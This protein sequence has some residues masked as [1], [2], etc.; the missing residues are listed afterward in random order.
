M[1]AAAPELIDLSGETQ[2]TLD[3][4]GVDRAGAEGCRRPRR[5]ARRVSA[6][7]PR[8]CLLARRL[9]ERGVRFVTLIHA[10]WDHHSNLDDELALQLPAW[11]TSRWPRCSRTSSSA[12]CSTRRWWSAP[13]SSAARRWARTA[14]ATHDG[15]GRDH[16]PF[17]FSLWMAGGG[18]KGGQ[19]L[20]KTDEHRLERR[21]RP[22]AR[23]RLPRH[24][25]AP[26]RPRPPAADAPL[27]GLE[28]AADE[29]GRERGAE[30]G[31]V[32]SLDRG[33]PV[34][35]L[36]AEHRTSNIEHPTSNGF[37]SRFEGSRAFA[38]RGGH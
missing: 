36:R 33:R 11:P 3:A 30:A 6:R 12:A 8:N 7:S 1:Q 29:L 13:A 25:P 22:G 16:H 20:G 31:G 4:Y 2:A 38:V 23:Q 26:V 9:V 37:G 10:S 14:T 18:I 34:L 24:D 21:R 19:V 32:A 27:L 28:P 17:A 5:R 35:A 15:T